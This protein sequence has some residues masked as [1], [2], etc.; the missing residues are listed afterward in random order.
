M[1]LIIGGV[2]WVASIVGAIYVWDKYVAEKY[3]VALREM[4]TKTKDLF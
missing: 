1:D 4:A 3:R 2:L